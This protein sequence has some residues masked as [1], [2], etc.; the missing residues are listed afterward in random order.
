MLF[1]VC[2]R[3]LHI[4][5]LSMSMQHNYGPVCHVFR[6]KKI[7][8]KQKSASRL[9]EQKDFVNCYKAIKLS[10]CQGKIIKK[11]KQK[12]YHLQ[13]VGTELLCYTL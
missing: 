12:R 2:M 5:T 10:C 7:T 1:F 13:P 11:Q 6:S 9:G 4:Y 3:F 8:D